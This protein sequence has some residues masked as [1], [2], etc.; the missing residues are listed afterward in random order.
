MPSNDLDN[1]DVPA[2]KR[3][4]IRLRGEV[5]NGDEVARTLEDAYVALGSTE[6]KLHDLE[7]AYLL[8]TKELEQLRTLAE[9]QGKLLEQQGAYLR[10]MEKLR[11][12]SVE[13]RRRLERDVAA[14]AERFA[15]LQRRHAV[16]STAFATASHQ[17]ETVCAE[18]AEIEAYVKR[19][20]SALA[21]ARMRVIAAERSTH[22]GLSI[23]ADD[24]GSMAS[25]PERAE[26]VGLLRKRTKTLL[27]QIASMDERLAGMEA[28]RSPQ[29]AWWR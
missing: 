18:R 24:A 28:T 29:R 19:L 20:A 25:L 15:E 26:F 22:E 13:K 11:L 5:A 27:A 9:E 8:T 2:L 21:R 3:E 7:Q 1:L 6:A 23:F 14:A 10:D 4:V 16:M 12:R 17:I